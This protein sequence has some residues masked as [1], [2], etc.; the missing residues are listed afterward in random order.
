MS[1]QPQPQPQQVSFA[2]QLAEA[3]SDVQS[4]LSARETAQT[5]V[6]TSTE[7]VAA[8]EAALEQAQGEQ[9][10]ASSGQ[11]TATDALRDSLTALAASS[12]ATAIRCRASDFRPPIY[13]RRAIQAAGGAVREPPPA[14]GTNLHTALLSA[15]R[16]AG[17]ACTG[18]AR[19]GAPPMTA[20]TA[21]KDE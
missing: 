17:R 10:T 3:V 19:L 12:P 1:T 20:L 5:S 8:A 15:C 16:E 4:K 13:G 2:T 6:S 11:T 18:A 9:Q 14:D 21:R 7:R